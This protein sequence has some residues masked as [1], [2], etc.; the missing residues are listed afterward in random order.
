MK[1]L[2]ISLLALTT[3]PAV[4]QMSMDHPMP[5]TDAELSEKLGVVSFPVSCLPSTQALFNRGVALLHD[6]WYSEAKRQFEAIVKADPTCAMAHWGLAMSDFHQIWGR[7][8]EK[9][10]ASAWAQMQ[11]AQ[12]PPAKTERERAYIAALSDFFKPGKQDFQTRID[13]YSV[14]MGKLYEQYPDVD[15]GAFYAL[16]L[17]AA[18]APTDTSQTNEHKAMAVLVPSS[19]NIPTIRAW[20]TTSFTPAITPQW[21][22]R[23][24]RHRIVTARSHPPARTPFTCPDTSIPGSVCG[25]RTSPHNWNQLRHRRMPRSAAKTA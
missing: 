20:S 2:A 23:A 5:S 8:D 11:L 3:F 19:R 24:W 1:I 21:R 4:A 14:A 9:T 25:R 6:F 15:S 17:L 12:T 16:S 13:A 7:P 22:L 10:T 18:E